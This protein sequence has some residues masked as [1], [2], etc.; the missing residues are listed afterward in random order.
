LKPWFD[1]QSHSQHSDG[2]LTPGAVVAAAAA[3]GVKLLSLTDH[4]TIDGVAEAA[5]AARAHAVRLVSGVEISALDAG[6][7][8]LHILGYL[9]DERDPRLRA[10]LESY[11]RDRQARAEAMIAAVRELGFELDEEPLHA[12]AAHGKS[13]GRPH[14]A[15]AVVGH[16][17]NAQ[18]LEA[19][20]CVDPSAF[21][22]AYLIEGR[23][24][25]RPRRAPSVPDAIA[26]IHDAAGVAVWAHPF[27][28]VAKPEE[29]LDAIDRFVAAG[30]DGVECFYA[31]HGR[32]QAELLA[33]RC[34]ELSL[35]STGSADFHGPHHREF[36]R[37]LAFST[38]GREPVLGPIAG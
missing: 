22:E 9:V 20:D 10:R 4:D 32:E 2:E 28:D 17:T 26:A 12:R 19:E 36:S 13:V 29:V 24:A 16:A 27:W 6:R 18:R 34:A 1:L 5:D 25:F 35:L 8:D 23:P 30:L 3:A 38:F 15:E 37:F 21:L 7:R 33:D 31:T 14:I 11:R